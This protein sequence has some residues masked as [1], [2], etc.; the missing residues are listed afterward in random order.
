MGNTS[1]LKWSKAGRGSYTAL[2]IANGT[3]MDVRGLSQNRLAY[4][5]ADPVWGV[6]NSTGSKRMEKTPSIIDH[7]KSRMDKLRLSTDGSVVEFVANGKPKRF[8]VIDPQNPPAASP[9]LNA[10]KTSAPGLSITD[11]FD[12]TTPKL[13]GK[14]LGLK[15][16][17]TSRSL[18][19]T[20]D[21]QHFLSGGDWTL[22]FM[23]AWGE[24]NGQGH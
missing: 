21:A 5:T 18:A 7:R 12:K 11:W 13:N 2:P 4:G 22:G 19:I 16:H 10:P 24:K 14:P 9:P 17:E 6:M 1:L 3:I 23:T 15:A 20:A 8:N